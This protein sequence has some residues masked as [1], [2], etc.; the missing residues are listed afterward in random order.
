MRQALECE[1]EGE[2]AAA[3]RLYRLGA[4]TAPF[5]PD[6]SQNGSRIAV[7]CAA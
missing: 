4:A 1:L 7:L 3:L 6:F 2:R 5:G